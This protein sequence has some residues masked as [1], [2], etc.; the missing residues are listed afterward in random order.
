MAASIKLEDNRME[1]DSGL[2]KLTPSTSSVRTEKDSNNGKATK[3]PVFQCVAP[4]CDQSGAGDLELMRSVLEENALQ[5]LTHESVLKKPRLE[6]AALPFPRK[7]WQIVDSDRFKSIKWDQDGNYVV[8]DEELFKTEVLERNGCQRIFETDCVKSFIRQLNLY[9]FTKV[10]LDPHRSAS[11]ADF[12][13]QE[14]EAVM[15]SKFQFYYNPNFRR[16]FPDLLTRMKRRIGIKNALSASFGEDADANAA[17]QSTGATSA[18]QK[19]GTTT[20]SEKPPENTGVTVGVPCP[21]PA[22]SASQGSN[23][24]PKAAVSADAQLAKAVG[25]RALQL[26]QSSSLPVGQPVRTDSL[27]LEPSSAPAT[28]ASIY[29]WMPPVPASGFGQLTPFP[30]FPPAYPDIAVA[31]AYLASWLPLCN[32]WFS[33]PMMAAASAFSMSAR[34]CT[35]RAPTPPHHHCAS[36]NCARNPDG[37]PASR[38]AQ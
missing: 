5:L 21:P 1:V 14:K 36:C 27:P 37:T 2:S 17:G 35:P 9:G 26:P 11:L 12:L 19:E 10:R 16:G 34:S 18:G 29:H 25:T 3:P 32:P 15:L 24:A 6:L 8:L 4:I 20:S 28:T 38:Q 33:M 7:L 30:S 13:A 31:Q 22:L 23:S